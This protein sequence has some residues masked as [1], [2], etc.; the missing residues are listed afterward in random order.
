MEYP[1]DGDERI[2]RRSIRVAKDE[3]VNLLVFQV[4]SQTTDHSWRVV[5]MPITISQQGR[6]LPGNAVSF[7]PRVREVFTT[8]S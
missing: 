4:R 1:F 5:Q 3:A 6:K 2:V 8:S 7:N